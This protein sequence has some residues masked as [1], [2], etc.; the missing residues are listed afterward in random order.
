MKILTRSTAVYLKI[1]QMVKLSYLKHC[2][3]SLG[4]LESSQELVIFLQIVLHRLAD[5]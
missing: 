5:K 2:I 1:K 4:N 3:Q